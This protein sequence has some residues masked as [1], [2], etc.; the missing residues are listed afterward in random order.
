MEMTGSGSIDDKQHISIVLVTFGA[1]AGLVLGCCGCLPLLIANVWSAWDRINRER[2]H[3]HKAG[4]Q[5]H[6]RGSRLDLHAPHW[7]QHSNWQRIAPSEELAEMS[8]TTEMLQTVGM[9][10]HSDIEPTPS[11][12]HLAGLSI[13]RFQQ[14]AIACTQNSEENR[15]QIST[16]SSSY[17]QA[18]TQASLQAT[19]GGNRNGSPSMAAEETQ[20][21]KTIHVVGGIFKLCSG[22]EAWCVVLV[23][24]WV[25][26]ASQV[27]GWL[28][29][30]WLIYHLLNCPPNRNCH[31]YHTA[32][33]YHSHH[34]YCTYK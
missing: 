12:A 11:G 29:H 19:N 1:I 6:R 32:T 16:A 22:G 33:T 3:S 2:R 17:E 31:N 27:G 34:Q 26:I 21:K 23:D 25:L 4:T 7:L 13:C 14:H 8:D 28:P 18:L 15:D 9:L 24:G 30:P 20:R 10:H 5:K